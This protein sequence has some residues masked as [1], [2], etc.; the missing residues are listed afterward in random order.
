VT[1]D[2]SGRTRVKD[3]YVVSAPLAGN[4]ARMALDPGDTVEE[5]QELAQILSLEP[6]LM[7]ARS[8]AQAQA[9][10]SAA[11]AA[12]RQAR[13]T[14][15][16]I[17]ASSQ[18][19]ERE[20]ERQRGLAARGSVASLAAERAELAHRTSREELASAT[21]ATRVADYEQRVAEAALRRQG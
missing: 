4:V 12:A 19:A 1:V 17:E 13:S 8:R 9:R 6:P 14:R 16:R 10:V 15:S 3:R 20:S 21:F 7:D 18:F 11:R 5:G 2:E